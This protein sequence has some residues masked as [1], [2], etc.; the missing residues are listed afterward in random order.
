MSDCCDCPRCG[1]PHECKKCY[2]TCEGC[3][4]SYCCSDEF[5]PMV[6]RLDYRATV[7]DCWEHQH[8]DDPAPIVSFT[9]GDHTAEFHFCDESCKTAWLAK[10]N[11][12]LDLVMRAIADGVD[13]APSDVA[14][15]E[16]VTSETWH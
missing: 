5:S 4:R 7:R 15:D 14:P 9:S 12:H 2:M 16:D 3:R 1:A 13:Y 10:F 6:L 8:E 11:E